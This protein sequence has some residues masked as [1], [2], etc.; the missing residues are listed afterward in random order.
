LK[1]VY[2]GKFESV[3]QLP[4]GNLPPNAVKFD[5]PDNMEGIV[6]AAMKYCAAAMALGL[7]VLVLGLFV[8]GFSRLQLLES[9]ASF[10]LALGAAIL[11]LVP[12]LFI[13]ELLHAVCF[14]KN[15]IVELYVSLKSGTA[16]VTCTSPISKARF[17]FLS[18]LPNVVLGWLP[19]IA[20]V[21]F[22]IY[23]FWANVL[24]LYALMHISVGG[25]DYLNVT[26]ALRQ[27]PKGS[28]AQLSGINTYWFIPKEEEL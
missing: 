4:K 12:S 8:H 9:S 26:N 6:K 21:V 22:P 19:L 16:F 14:R 27:M 20:W 11:I 5:E 25:G 1:L 24:W 3:E 28:M 18:L 23:G 13:H 7:A 10:F 17:I 2:K 15:D